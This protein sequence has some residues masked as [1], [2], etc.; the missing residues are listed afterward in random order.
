MSRRPI[1]EL[2]LASAL[3]LGTFGVA[4]GPSAAAAPPTPQQLQDAQVR[5]QQSQQALTSVQARAEQ[6][7]EAYNGA[8]VAASQAA[9]RSG[10]AADGQ[11]ATG[12]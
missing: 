6:A 2:A 9:D 4:G 11:V 8:I 5:V 3:V 1:L 7:A 12:K 10:A